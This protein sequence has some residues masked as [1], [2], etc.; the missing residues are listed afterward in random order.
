MSWSLRTRVMLTAGAVL[1]LALGGSGLALYVLVRNTLTKNFD[2]TLVAQIRTLSG[3]VQIDEKSGDLV[4]KK[5]SDQDSELGAIP[6]LY[7]FTAQGR[8]GIRHTPALSDAFL[9]NPKSGTV[10]RPE[11]S[12]QLLANGRPGRVASARIMMTAP[13]PKQLEYESHEEHKEKEAEFLNKAVDGKKKEHRESEDEEEVEF[14]YEGIDANGKKVH[15]HSHT[16][17]GAEKIA[18]L[19]SS[20]KPKPPT[21]APTAVPVDIIIAQEVAGL[22][23]DLAMI[24]WLLFLVTGSTILVSEWLMAWAVR[25]SL[26]PLNRLADSIAKLGD[27]DFGKR[28]KIQGAPTELAPVIDHLNDLLSSIDKVLA[29]E[30][31]FSADVSHELRTPL[32]GLLSTIDVCLRK[33]RDPE[34]YQRALTT[35]R[36]ITRQMQSVVGNLLDLTRLESKRTV[37]PCE[38]VDLH[39][40][41]GTQWCLY[42]ERATL[43]HVTV[44]WRLNHGLAMTNADRLGQIISNLFDN[45]VSYVNEGGM[46]TV[47]SCERDGKQEIIIANTGSQISADQVGQVFERFW[48]SDRARADSHQHCGLGLTLCRRLITVLG[49]TITVKS[50]LGGLFEV[51]LIVPA[52]DLDGEDTI[53]ENTPRGNL[54]MPEVKINSQSMDITGDNFSHVI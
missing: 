47:N 28:I 16:K 26:R 51:H 39:R 20:E 35:C 44:K 10:L 37:V 22:D 17:A 18:S 49:G 14:E 48:R 46:I 33:P 6:D 50:Q 29:R 2:E 40:L 15:Y 36:R 8:R 21:P 5:S 4:M 30:R 13:A 3:L 7:E 1:G 42:T 52:A 25:R 23:H 53:S 43:R 27:D 9:P 32:S 34:N 11:I 54:V 41:I 24:G 38:P 19:I 12:P 31:G 45:A